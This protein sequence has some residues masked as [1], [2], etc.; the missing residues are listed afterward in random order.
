MEAKKILQIG[1]RIPLQQEG[2][3][4]A[5][6]QIGINWGMIR[7]KKLFGL[8][9]QKETVDLDVSVILMNDKW[10]LKDHVYYGK[11]NSRDEAISHTGDDMQGDKHGD[12]GMDNEVLRIDL[13]KIAKNID[14]IYFIINNF[15]EQK[16]V[17]VPYIQVNIDK[18]YKDHKADT[19]ASFDL[20]S[21]LPL[22]NSLAL[23]I[24]KI[25]R[26]PD[27]QWE[28]LALGT[29]MKSAQL[30]KIIEEIREY[31]I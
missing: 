11:L 16:F 20:S 29:K 21:T 25:V 18:Y 22:A 24:G 14:Y 17:D 10:D 6:L 8:I 12:D 5:I 9:T 3:D 26:T 7:H 19:I 4:S 27:N 28:F 31:K 23:V 2:E 1:Q 30:P 13:D 15:K